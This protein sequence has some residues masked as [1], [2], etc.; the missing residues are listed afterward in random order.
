ME[1]KGII[2]GYYSSGSEGTGEREDCM[3]K[4]N[5]F[6]E[7][8][9]NLA[10]GIG[11]SA[12]IL[13]GDFCFEDV[14]TNIPIYHAFSDQKEL[15]DHLIFSN[16]GKGVRTFT[17]K[18]INQ[19]Y[20]K[21]E[22]LENIAAIEHVLGNISEGTVVGLVGS[23]DS[24]AI[25]VHNLKENEMVKKIRE[26]EERISPQVVRA[27]LSIC[28]DVATK[29]REGKK[30][31]T[32]LIVGDVDEVMHRSHPLIINPYLGQTPEDSN[33]IEE[34]NW[35]SVKELAQLDGVFVISEQGR[36][37]AAGRYLDVD[38]RDINIDKG[39]GGRHVSA[40]AITRDTVAVAFIVS[41]PGGVVRIYKDGKDIICIDSP[42]RCMSA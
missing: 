8:A 33:I 12:I 24:C 22:E 28:F 40:A 32:A 38:A 11:S 35:E 20:H 14:R 10:E 27:V 17:D 4:N 16:G 41:E 21:L 30:V 19:S 7:T 23:I 29:G 37:H 1:Q 25:V 5:V 36:I 39:L 2:A 34:H 18:M 9:V 26:C 6:I 3:E 42:Q 31:G 13:A 15:I